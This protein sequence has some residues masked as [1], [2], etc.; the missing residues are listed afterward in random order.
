MDSKEDIKSTV[1]DSNSQTAAMAD[2]NLN[3]SFKS[4]N[5]KFTQKK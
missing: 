3:D 1:A 5:T 2:K 4:V